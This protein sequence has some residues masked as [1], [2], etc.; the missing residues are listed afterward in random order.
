MLKKEKLTELLEKY[1]RKYK[2]LQK[3]VIENRI[4]TLTLQNER[5]KPKEI[6]NQLSQGS[7]RK[8]TIDE[9]IGYLRDLKL[10]SVEMCQK[11]HLDVTKFVQAMI[12]FIK[13]NE[14]DFPLVLKYID[15][16]N[17]IRQHDSSYEIKVYRGCLLYLFL[18]NEEGKTIPNHECVLNFKGI[19]AKYLINE[20]IDEM[21]QVCNITS[22]ESDE[23]I[24]NMIDD[25][26]NESS[27]PSDSLDKEQLIELLEFELNNMRN[28]FLQVK[29]LYENQNRRFQKLG[30][31]T[32]KE[33]VKDFFNKLNADQYGNLLDKF[34]SVEQNLIQ[35]RQSGYVF[36]MEVA[37]IPLIIKLFM[38]YIKESGIE[39]IEQVGREF[40]ATVKDIEY[41]NYNGEPFMDELESKWVKVVSSG[42][43]YQD[44]IISIPSII[45]ISE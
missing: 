8:F 36:P 27:N 30:E 7:H 10:N 42:W 24:L 31:R 11:Y 13:G 43:K 14:N 45:E 29:R 28:N 38:K 21:K 32:K 41:M 1:D 39:M 37:S 25:A 3:V 23:H 6:A 18:I 26:L 44:M 17:Q 20:I 2:Y 16:L 35:V 15:V 19:T 34:S 12:Q 40:K 9:V 4:L 5:I 33:V 22:D